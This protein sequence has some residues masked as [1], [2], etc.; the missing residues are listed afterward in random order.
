[1]DPISKKGPSFR[2]VRVLP[3]G[4]WSH[5]YWFLKPTYTLI[6]YLR[7]VDSF[8]KRSF[9]EEA[10]DDLRKYEAAMAAEDREIRERAYQTGYERGEDA[11]REG[12]RGSRIYSYGSV[13]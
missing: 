5:V 12:E 4:R 8:N 7:R 2:L 11:W 1:M 10:L 3:D 13:V 9:D 6:K